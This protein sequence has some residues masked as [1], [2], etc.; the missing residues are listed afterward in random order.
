MTFKYPNSSGVME[1]KGARDLYFFGFLCGSHWLEYEDTT[2]KV[3]SDGKDISRH[4]ALTN[5]LAAARVPE[6]RRFSLI[7]IRI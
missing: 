2:M 5:M 3:S 7:E 4:D 6:S 1:V